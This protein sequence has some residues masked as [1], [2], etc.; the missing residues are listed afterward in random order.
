MGFFEVGQGIFGIMLFSFILLVAF[1]GMQTTNLTSPLVPSS[2]NNPNQINI[3]A[4][5]ANS[6]F[7]GTPS[8]APTNVNLTENNQ[9]LNVANQDLPDITAVAKAIFFSIVQMGEFIGLPQPIIW[10]VLV[11]LNIIMNIFVAFFLINVA[12]GALGRGGGV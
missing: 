5:D 1:A 6:S 4:I 3:N 12:A 10:I 11:P 2:L 9:Y 8:L 7:A